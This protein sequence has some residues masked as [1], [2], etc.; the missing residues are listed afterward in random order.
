VAAVDASTGPGPLGGP[1]D[2]VEHGPGP[3]VV[4]LHG[5]R[6]RPDALAPFAAALGA[7]GAWTFPAGGIDAGDGTLGWWP[8]DAAARAR[9]VGP[10][11]LS[12]VSPAGLPAARARLAAV[13]EAARAAR[14]DR[15]CVVGGFSQG[16]MLAL[17]HALAASRP[18]D[19]LVLLSASRLAWADCLRQLPRLR[20]VPTLV[21]HGRDDPELAFDGARELARALADAGADV[22]WLPFDGGH[23]TPLP[24]W[25][26]VRRLLQRVTGNVSTCDPSPPPGPS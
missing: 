24:A 4:M 10:R 14:P 1:D 11:D 9:A 13:V 6:M 17:H 22:E 15:P 3:L 19:G 20:G 7:G 16:G 26:G 5:W 18:V 2:I 25:R 21:A 23:A 8:V 12:D